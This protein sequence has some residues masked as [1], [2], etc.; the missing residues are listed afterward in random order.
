MD[1]IGRIRRLHLRD[2]ISE[3]E[4][5]GCRGCR[6]TRYR[7]GYERQEPNFPSTGETRG[8]TNA[9]HSRQRSSCR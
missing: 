6:A 7:S 8:R 3:R 4:T 2:N 5:R 1:M 9:A